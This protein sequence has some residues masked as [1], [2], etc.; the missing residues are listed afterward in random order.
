[1]TTGATASLSSAVR[2]SAASTAG[3]A[4]RVDPSFL[5]TVEA[6]SHENIRRC[7][8]CLKCTAGCPTA[9]AMDYGPAHVLKLVQLGQK[10]KV[11]QSKAIWMCVGCETCWTRCPNG[12]AAGHVMDALKQ[13]ALREGY[14]PAERRVLV[15]HRQF[16]TSIRLF[17]RVHELSM[18]A[19]YKLLSG[20][21]FTD[22]DLGARM[23]LRGKIPI[24]P[25]RIKGM[26]KI[27]QLFAKRPRGQE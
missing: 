4:Q 10:D 24:L 22:L 17:G 6:L 13:M 18:L 11:L 19:L 25:E 27:Q 23:F 15:L 1:M 7:Y 12:I 2:T 16:L 20:D 14:A 8:Y 21:L 5:P 3:N 26:S 9:Y